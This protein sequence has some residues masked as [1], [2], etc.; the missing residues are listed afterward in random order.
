M[1]N[2]TL[3]RRSMLVQ[4]G[5]PSLLM[6]LLLL[7]TTVSLAAPRPP[8]IVIIFT[9]DQGYADVGVFGAKDFST[10]NLDRMARE[11]I[12]FTD[13][14]VAQAVCS[15]SRAALLTGCYP[16]RIGI[17][18][19]LDHRAKHGISAD[20]VTIAELLKA[21]GYRTALFGKW[22]LGHHP[23]FLPTRHGFDEYFGLPYSNDMWPNHPEAKPGTYPA[24]PLIEGDKSKGERVVQLMPDQTRLT[25]WYTERAV[26]FIERN[27][28]RPFFLYVPHT[29]PHVPLHASDR[30]KGKS[31][32]GLYGDVIQEIDWSVGEILTAIKKHELDRDTLVIFTSDNG[33]WLSY[34]GHAGSAGRLREGKQTIWEG[35]TRV[36]FIA[37]WPGKIPAG[38]VN[39]EPAM[40]IDLLP[41]IAKLAGAELPKHK[42]DGLDIWPLLAGRTGATSP[43]EAFFFYYNSNELQAVRSGKWKLTLPHTSRAFAGQQGRNDGLPV[44]YQTVKVGRELYDLENDVGETTNVADKHPRVVERLE[45]LAERARE[46]MG[47]RLTERA[48][49]GVRAPGRLTEANG[50]R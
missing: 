45:A 14:H 19:A 7:P 10:P 24:L 2:K 34:G 16:N 32:G 25:G 29:M 6:L 13:F 47:D 38:R 27:K 37:R 8:N 42:I 4:R 28:A 36:P 43:H 49:R 18:G 22:H 31:K 5:M 41:T 35:G 33:P 11:G 12:R 15:A 17:H 40:T 20:E 39:R 50:A 23:Q 44:K 21:R 3:R 26:K 9:D 48:G 1:M 30:F 46:D